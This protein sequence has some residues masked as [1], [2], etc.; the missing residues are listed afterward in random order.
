MDVK[1]ALM[2][3]KV[4][5]DWLI[6]QSTG[7]VLIFHPVEITGVNFWVGVCKW[8]SFGFES[9]GVLGLGEGKID[10]GSGSGR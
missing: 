6:R 10:A 9:L 7:Y 1:T 2:H 4:T 5:W 8:G 3:H